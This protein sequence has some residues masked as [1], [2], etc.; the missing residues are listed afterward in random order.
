MVLGCSTRVWSCTRVCYLDADRRTNQPREAASTTDT[1][2]ATVAVAA[3]SSSPTVRRTNQP[4]AAASTADTDAATVAAAA[5]SSSPTVS[6]TS[7]VP[8]GPRLARFPCAVGSTRVQ[9]QDSTRA[10]LGQPEGGAQAVLGQY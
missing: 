4:R 7:L 9:Y 5:G 3:G 1:A 6:S 2:A 10:V 8:P